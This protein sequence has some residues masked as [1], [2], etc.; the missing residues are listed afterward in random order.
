MS[1]MVIGGRVGELDRDLGDRIPDGS[2]HQ[3]GL[4]AKF[5]D[6]GLGEGLAQLNTTAR[7]APSWRTLSALVGAFEEQQR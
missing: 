7:R 4:F 2:D 5:A 6:R 1:D 3:T